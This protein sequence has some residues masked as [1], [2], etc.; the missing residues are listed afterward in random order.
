MRYAMERRSREI[1][2]AHKAKAWG[3]YSCPTCKAGVFLRSGEYR[4]PHFAHMPRQGK[5]ECEEFHPSNELL[6]S[7]RSGEGT[8][9]APSVDP[10]LLS[11]ELEPD[12]DL[13]QGPRKWVLRL[14]VPKTHDGHGQFLIDLGGDDI[15][16]VSLSKLMRD[17]AQTY[18]LDITADDYGAKWI[19]PEVRP[20]YRAVI[21]G[22]IPGLDK[23]GVTVFRAT[24]QKQ[25][26]LADAFCWGESY[27]LVWRADAPISLPQSL[28][29]RPLAENHG[30]TCVLVALP[31][32]PDQELGRWLEDVC[33]LPV[34]RARREW[35][36][37]YPPSY[38][39]DDEGCLFIPP[40]E[41]ILLTLK[42]VDVE[43]PGELTCLVNQSS[44][45]LRLSGT[46][47]F[48]VGLDLTK[49][50][51]KQSAYLAWDGAPMTS[52]RSLA[53]VDNAVDNGIILCFRS[54]STVRQAALHREM[55]RSLLTEVRRGAAVLT[56]LRGHPALNGHL[57]VRPANTVDWTLTT[58]ALSAGSG[59][60]SPGM[61]RADLVE[62]LNAALR[63]QSS[64]CEI[65][66]GPFGLFA[67]PGV[68]RTV[69]I[70][71]TPKRNI[72]RALRSR[73]E[74]LCKTTGALAAQDRVPIARLDDH[75]LL[76]HFARLVPPNGLLAHKR[77][78][79]RELG[80]VHANGRLP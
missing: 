3:S 50:G 75:A 23:T 72:T 17:G 19:S 71:P 57:R 25:K 31:H 28:T 44:T 7:W 74:W 38:A 80:A 15:R 41:E 61:M 6:H 48:F 39:I 8:P 47:P 62:Q 78:I 46:Q 76:L 33:H 73:I 34:V 53:V 56:E 18:S 20:E 30:W 22:R 77:A 43:Q 13:R 58:L 10:L 67:S 1:V 9:N 79:E 12:H 70:V 24:S 49:L 16:K 11:I 63:D 69:A 42:A 66:F 45:P 37:M 60:G 51:A 32:A 27:Y 14:T 2:P 68:V 55:C 64:D 29:N 5:P 26:P 54:R 59:V 52:L 40:S 21:E 65:D 36:I 4:V 35:A